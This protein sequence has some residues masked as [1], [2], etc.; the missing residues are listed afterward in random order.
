MGYSRDGFYRFKELYEQ[1]CE[2]GL[3]ETSKK[4]NPKNRLAQTDFSLVR[5]VI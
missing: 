3:Q 1:H 2:A 4:P 5:R